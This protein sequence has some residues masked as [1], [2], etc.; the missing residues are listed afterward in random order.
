M[1]FLRTT[2][3]A[4]AFVAVSGSFA[5]ATPPRPVAL[6]RRIAE[7]D[8]IVVGKLK[9]QPVHCG[10]AYD[11]EV[12]ETLKGVA[13][14]EVRVRS[15]HYFN[16]DVV[17]PNQTQ[18]KS[19][20]AG[21]RRA[22]FFC[23]VE[24][25]AARDTSNVVTLDPD[26]GMPATFWIGVY[27]RHHATLGPAAVKAL[28]DIDSV[29]TDETKAS[30]LWIKGLAS[31]NPILVEALLDRYRIVACGDPSRSAVASDFG[32]ALVKRAQRDVAA[33]PTEIL[34]AVLAHCADKLPPHR[35]QALAC[36]AEAYGHAAAEDR[37]L[38]LEA[39]AAAR[40]SLRDLDA[41]VRSV[42]RWVLAATD[43][44]DAVS[45]LADAL[46]RRDEDKSQVARAVDLAV[47]LAKKGGDRK[48]DVIT[49]FI[50]LLDERDDGRPWEMDALRKITNQKFTDA[51]AWKTWWAKQKK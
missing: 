27:A 3:A 13:P 35:I 38:F 4:A 46:R 48:N 50:A 2:L 6:E 41:E 24:K 33:A 49:L 1:K 37:P 19:L 43:N 51:E 22:L 17:G 40:A 9:T 11:V 31:G 12:E 26:D 21:A 14:T 44:R 39:I 47:E 5:A 28:V 20:E 36:A 34:V 29:L 15:P 8:L 25:E 30:D 10:D 45:A 16:G 18:P 7:S 23:G 42:S 32:D